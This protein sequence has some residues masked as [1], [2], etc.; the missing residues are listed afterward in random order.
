MELLL[1]SDGF[2][3]ELAYNMSHTKSKI[4]L[5]TMRARVSLM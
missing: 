3:F 1:T 5:A 2:H 4:T